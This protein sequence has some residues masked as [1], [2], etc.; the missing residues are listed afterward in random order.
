MEQK[1]QMIKILIEKCSFF[2]RNLPT[3]QTVRKGKS[4]INNRRKKRSF[5]R[6]LLFILNLQKPFFK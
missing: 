3:R 4:E 6:N 2:I 5:W 1:K